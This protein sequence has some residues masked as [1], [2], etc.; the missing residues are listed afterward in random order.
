M[1]DLIIPYYNNRIGLLN[2]LKSIDQSIFKVT[3]VDDHSTETPIFPLD[4]ADYFR[5]NINSGP[6]VARQ[7]GIE[8][9]SNPYIMFLDTGDIFISHEVQKDIAGTIAANPNINIFSFSYYYKDE[10]TKETDNRLHGKV[11]KRDFLKKYGITFAAESSYLDE[12]IGF[13][14]T[15]RYCTEAAAQ[16]LLFFNSPVIKWIENSNSLTQKDNG[17]VLY[18]DQTRALSL[19]S[20]HTIDIL[21]ANDIN[22]EIEINQ[23]GIAL[24]YWF[25]RTAAERKEYI[26]DAWSGARIFYTKLAQDIKPNHLALGN[27]YLK[28]CL[29]YRNQIS[30]PINILRF[31][32]DI[33]KNEIIPDKYLTLN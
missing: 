29:Q 17:I 2:T 23:I 16:P 6:G 19:T 20:L 9:T 33:Q 11:Y 31:A 28:K 3:I 10:P 5:L 12:D 1:I 26:Q 4:N 24:Y 8:K 7:Q 13:N 14:R 15:C 30:F 32:D 27:A 25:I 22:P 18:R 21:R